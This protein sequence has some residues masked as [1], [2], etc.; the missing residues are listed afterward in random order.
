MRSSGEARDERERDEQS[1]FEQG[2]LQEKRIGE[3]ES[4]AF[5]GEQNG[6]QGDTGS[7]RRERDSSFG[8]K[9][10][11]EG[12]PAG[13]IA[14]AAENDRQNAA[15]VKEKYIQG[16]DDVGEDDAVFVVLRPEIAEVEGLD[17][18]EVFGNAPV[19]EDGPRRRTWRRWRAG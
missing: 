6:D 2:P 16:E 12:E 8:K 1:G 7:A 15:A 5:P 17:A 9:G 10:S 14:E 18:G 3:D 13:E 11:G 19:V 4:G